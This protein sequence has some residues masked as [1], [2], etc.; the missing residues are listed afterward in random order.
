MSQN[1]N[2]D[3]Q[4][5]LA[6][7]SNALQDLAA[8]VYHVT[9]E[10]AART[11]GNLRVEAIRQEKTLTERFLAYMEMGLDRQIVQAVEP[12]RISAIAFTDRGNAYQTYEQET[13]ADMACFIRYD[14]P[15]LRWAKGFLGQSKMA[16]VNDYDDFG[17]P[18][19]GLPTEAD[20][21]E[22]IEN[23]LAMRKITEESYVFFF[24][25]DSVTV[26]KT[27]ALLNDYYN[28]PSKPWQDV[29]RFRQDQKGVDIAKFYAAFVSCQVGDIL[30]DRP[31]AGFD[32]MLDLITARGIGVILLIMVGSVPP[33][34]TLSKDSDEL[35][36][37]PFEV[38]QT[39]WAWQHLFNSLMQKGE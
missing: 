10:A 12:L 2:S 8:Y 36:A 26:E 33:L 30:L 15:G 27:G 37:L 25:P 29:H 39:Y 5:A 21:D 6:R 32:S 23:A 3:P 31:A 18:Q 14:L 17:V 11:M 20:Y 19:V 22:M 28:N 38:P 9:V 34:P 4:Q 35:K 7:A 16:V 13:G 24:S 1:S